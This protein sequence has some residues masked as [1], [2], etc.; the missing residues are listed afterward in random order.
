VRPVVIV[1]AVLVVAGAALFLR[2]IVTGPSNTPDAAVMRFMQAYATYDAQGMLDNST[3]SSFTTTDLAAF[4]QD[5]ASVPADVKAR[6]VYTDIKIVSAI[7]QANDPNIAI[8]KLSAMMLD[9]APASS[10]AATSATAAGTYSPR[11][12]TLTVVKSSAG[13]WLVK[14]N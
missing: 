1:L 8:V 2:A 6:P 10:S 14:W 7:I 11:D 3:H 4:Q 5:L 9:N 12:E 13:K